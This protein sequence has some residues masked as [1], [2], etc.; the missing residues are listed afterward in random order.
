MKTLN[1]A[2]IGLGMMGQRHARI[3]KELPQTELLGVYDI[4]P[5]RTQEWAADLDCQAAGSLAELLA[6]PGLDLVSVCTD[7]QLH[8]EPCLAAAAAGKHI[9]LEKPL[10]TSVADADAII[11]ACRNNNITLMV[12]HVVRFDPR[13]QVGQ[14]AIDAGEVGEIVQV[15][16]RRN[17][18][19][20]SG[21]RI[22]SRTS[23]AF[24]L[25]AH[26]LDLMRWFCGSGVVKVHAESAS[27]VLT[28]LG[29]EDSIFTV[30]KFANGA[31]GCLE[32]CWVVPEGVPNTL[33]ARLEVVGTKGRVAV[34][35][36]DESLEIASPT[37][38]QR[39]DIAYGPVFDGLQQGALRTQLEHFADCLRTGRAPLVSVE[40]ARAA[41]VIC[42]AIHESLR[43]GQPVVLGSGG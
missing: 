31:V 11:A 37:R 40:D 34:R 22:G 39:P 17:N 32:T 16:G 24:F 19:V 3:W 1:A 23:V 15:F 4:V 12:G 29:C 6:L 7:D 2:V 5:E 21:R 25:G 30:M 13:Y 38:A 43:S 18:I 42:E 9:L 35:V 33:D 41:V 36:G 8:V 20:A 14:Q 10:A 28:D 26:D 27:K